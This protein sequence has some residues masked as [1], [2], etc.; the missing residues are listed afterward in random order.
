MS[1]FHEKVAKAILTSWDHGAG[2]VWDGDDGPETYVQALA[3][4]IGDVI[5]GE[6]AI[7]Q[8]IDAAV[9][10]SQGQ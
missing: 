9:A 1:E 6:E 10:L 4:A 5:D 2:L 8:I 7:A 3:W